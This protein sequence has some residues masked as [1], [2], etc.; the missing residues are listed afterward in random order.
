MRKP[1]ET[2]Q[3][4]RLRARLGWF[5]SA[6]FA[7]VALASAA[8]PAVAHAAPDDSTV[9]GASV[10]ASASTG[11]AQ[12]DSRPGS[13]ESVRPS[14]WVYYASYTDYASCYSRG[15]K[16]SGGGLEWSDFECYR[17]ST[18]PTQYDLYVNTY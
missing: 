3:L 9:T 7:A 10:N 17:V 16:G 4:T 1:N 6:A 15:I 18:N 11:T 12:T 13:T 8:L 2:T 14:A 5:A